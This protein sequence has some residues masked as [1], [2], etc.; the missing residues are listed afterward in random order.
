L[1]LAID[2]RVSHFEKLMS[3]AKDAA[4][5]GR[6]PCN[7]FENL[8]APIFVP[9]ESHTTT[10][11]ISVCSRRPGGSYGHV[12]VAFTPSVAMDLSL[13]VRQQSSPVATSSY[14]QQPLMRRALATM[15]ERFDKSLIRDR[16]GTIFLRL[17]ETAKDHPQDLC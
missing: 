3:M 5:T 17:L 8:S 16:S 12:R 14:H 9:P 1:S 4:A 2:E 10:T 7:D 13:L 11:C 6:D 15:T